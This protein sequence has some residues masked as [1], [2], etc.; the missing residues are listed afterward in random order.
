MKR[1]ENLCVKLA[2]NVALENKAQK[3]TFLKIKID[4][5]E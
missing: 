1:V 2:Y 3:S 4:E 5:L